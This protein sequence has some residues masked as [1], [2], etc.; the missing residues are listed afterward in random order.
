M[1]NIPTKI[2]VHH[3]ADST[4]TDQLAKINEY[5]KNRDFPQSSL[6]YYVGYHFLIN[7]AGVL[8]QT[9]KLEDEG[10]HTKGLNFDSIGICLEG[11][12]SEELPTEAQ[13]ETLGKLFLQL[14]ELYK[15]DVTDIYPHRAFGNTSCYGDKLFDNWAG[16]L[17]LEYKA[18][19]IK[20]QISCEA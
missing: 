1:N 9:R 6:G 2:I 5:H 8:T 19:S 11:N 20:K 18:E 10:A 13:K 16:L 4:P 14:C 12:F 17:Y 3:S 7:H 15:F